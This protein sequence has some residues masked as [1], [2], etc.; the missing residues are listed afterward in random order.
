MLIV[1]PKLRMGLSSLEKQLGTFDFAELSRSMVQQEV[2]VSIP[3]FKIE[4]EIKLNDVLAKVCISI[5][6]K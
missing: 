1:L 6:T 5:K 2:E 3:K 4:F